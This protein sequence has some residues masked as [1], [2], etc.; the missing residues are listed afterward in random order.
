MI[1]ERREKR[2]GTWGWK[3]VIWGRQTP[4]LYLRGCEINNNPPVEVGCTRRKQPD[5]F[6]FDK[7]LLICSV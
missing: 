4:F 1:L 6:D 5:G 7:R 3:R 2:N